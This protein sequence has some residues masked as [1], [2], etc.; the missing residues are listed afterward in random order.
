MIFEFSFVI[1]KY[2]LLSVVLLGGIAKS[3]SAT[4]FDKCYHSVVCLYVIFH[5]C[6]PC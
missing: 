2:T 1:A 5:T 3:D 4:Y 6:A